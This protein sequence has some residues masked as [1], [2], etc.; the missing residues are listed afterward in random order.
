MVIY[1]LA[2]KEIVFEGKN[3][4]LVNFTDKGFI[5]V[6]NEKEMKNGLFAG[7]MMSTMS[8]V[9]RTG[10]FIHKD[11]PESKFNESVEYW[12]PLLPDGSKAVRMDYSLYGSS[13][14]Y[15]LNGKVGVF[16][17]YGRASRAPD[18]KWYFTN[19]QSYLAFYQDK[20]MMDDSVINYTGEKP[21]C[22]KSCLHAPYGYF[23]KGNR[24]IS[25]EAYSGT[26]SEFKEPIHFD[27]TDT[28]Y[29]IR[30]VEFMKNLVIQNRSDLVRGYP[31]YSFDEI[32]NTV[33]EL[34]AAGDTMV[35][36]NILANSGVYDLSTG[37]WIVPGEF[38]RVISTDKYFIGSFYPKLPTMTFMSSP[39]CFITSWRSL[40]MSAGLC[41]TDMPEA[42][43]RPP[44]TR[45]API[46]NIPTCIT[47]I[48]RFLR[49]MGLHR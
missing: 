39:F 15:N 40:T 2:K 25:V 19:Y 38:F 36:V 9:D 13:I 12:M 37:S 49:K 8:V 29:T 27:L 6:N 33:F 28:S 48:L 31:Q 46:D 3:Y 26:E 43:N 20:L 30:S 10:K 18:M 4:S 42:S 11:I 7:N 24:K 14:I 17:S 35:N 44:A 32:G 47:F 23:Q 5:L 41:A 45:A 34:N 22:V 16:G 21:Y 1:D